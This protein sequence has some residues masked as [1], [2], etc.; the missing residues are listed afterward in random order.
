M[1]LH[2]AVVLD[3]DGHLIIAANRKSYKRCFLKISDV[4]FWR[5][6]NY[7]VSVDNFFQYLIVSPAFYNDMLAALSPME[8][9]CA[10]L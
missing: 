9:H 2:E 4:S 8:F 5:D 1:F 6:M 10:E 7:A 3:L